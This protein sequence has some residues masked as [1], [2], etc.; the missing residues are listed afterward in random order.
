VAVR[1]DTFATFPPSRDHRFFLEATPSPARLSLAKQLMR[2]GIILNWLA[3]AGLAM[4]AHAATSDDAQRL[5]SAH[6]LPVLAENCFKCHGNIE[7]KSGL[8]VMTPAEVLKGGDNGPSVVPGKPEKSLLYK[9]VLPDAD[10]HMPPKGRALTIEETAVI[11]RWIEKLSPAAAQAATNES[12]AATSGAKVSPLFRKATWQ[13][14]KG[15][16]VPQSIDTLI[17]KRWRELKVKPSAVCDD[18]TFVRRVYLD[19]AGRIPTPEELDKF[20]ADKRRDK[21]AALVNQLLESPDY[22]VRMR[23]VFDAVFM[24]RG[25]FETARERRRR[26]GKM[27]LNDRW[28]DYLEWSFRTNRAW[29]VVAREIILARPNSDERRGAVQFLYARK[30]NAQQMAEITGSALLGLQTKC[31]QCHDHPLAPEIKQSHY[32]GMVAAFNRSKAVDTGA[33]PGVGESAVGG[34]IKFTNLKGGSYDALEVFLDDKLVAEA[35][36]KDGEKENDAAEKYINA[37]ALG[38]GKNLKQVPV[39]KFSRREQLADWMTSADNPLL[40][41]A[42]V[43]R[44]WAMLLGRGLVH[45]VDRMDSSRP[46]SHPELLDWLAEDFARHGYD[47]KRLVR[48]ITATRVY[49]LDSRPAGK[50]RPPVDSFACALDK[51]LTAEVFARSALIATGQDADGSLTNLAPV[52]KA[53][54][55][56]FPDV[57]PTENVSSPRQA[58]F[59]S[60]NQMLDGLGKSTSTNALAR[61]VSL[62]DEARVKELFVRVLGRNPDREEMKRSLDYLRERSHEPSAATQQLLWALLAGAEFRINH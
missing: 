44:V 50:S 30:D 24:E 22:A 29:N 11:K 43:N 7:T 27:E 37:V 26:G 35:R 56:A 6:V 58:L 3:M 9:Y 45:P 28:Q 60:N 61:I 40:A 49:Q 15:Q 62:P 25:A 4:H 10:P 51:P 54:T 53:F 20:L 47:V 18:H 42:F 46:P 32:W 33:G 41:R 31:A 36:P 52:Q 16:T 57:F 14:P 17:E 5:W 59:L 23:E 39:P 19:V 8:S 34:F 12:L 38:D 1:R 21:R 2:R 55:D 13:P 48:N